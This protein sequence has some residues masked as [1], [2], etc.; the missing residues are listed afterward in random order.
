M[1]THLH[2]HTGH[3]RDISLYAV[4]IITMDR[5]GARFYEFL[6]FRSSFLFVCYPYNMTHHRNALTTHMHYAYTESCILGLSFGIRVRP[7]KIPSRENS[8]RKEE[9][10]KKKDSRLE[11]RHN[12]KDEYWL[13][14]FI[15]R[16]EL[17]TLTLTVSFNHSQFSTFTHSIERMNG[18]SRLHMAFVRHFSWIFG[19]SL[20]KADEA[21]RMFYITNEKETNWC[22]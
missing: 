7:I 10:K 14:S 1:H 5:I 3:I 6:F 11:R 19:N 2:S 16:I 12:Q 18:D 4:I 17:L 20:P 13:S 15:Y 8:K 22:R 21:I 9:R